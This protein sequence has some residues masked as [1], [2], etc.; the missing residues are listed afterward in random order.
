MK[1]EKIDD[2]KWSGGMKGKGRVEKTKQRKVR[3]KE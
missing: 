1:H 2:W 3:E